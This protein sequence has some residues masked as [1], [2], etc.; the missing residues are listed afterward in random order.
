MLGPV[1]A[2][3]ISGY[4]KILKDTYDNESNDPRDIEKREMLWSRY[5]QVKHPGA[6]R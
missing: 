4:D 6:G 2:H 1:R 3:D 5:S